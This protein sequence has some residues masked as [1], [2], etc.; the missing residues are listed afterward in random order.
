MRNCRSAFPSLAINN[1]YN[2]R[3][4]S[5]HFAWRVQPISSGDF[6]LPSPHFATINHICALRILSL[7]LWAKDFYSLL[8]TNYS[9]HTTSSFVLVR[10]AAQITRGPSH[11]P[12]LPY[13]YETVYSE[14]I[15]A[16][17]SGAKHHSTV[18][19][20]SMRV[21]FASARY[22]WIPSK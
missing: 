14:H 3:E 1:I 18:L 9:C 17:R 16:I 21:I 15:T 13:I 2:I 6:K 7:I 22:A 11:P 10:C 8:L 5:K 20:P 19:A 12:T 4:N